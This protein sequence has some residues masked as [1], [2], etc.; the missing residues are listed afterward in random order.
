MLCG[1]KLGNLICNKKRGEPASFLHKESLKSE[2]L[3]SLLR[4]KE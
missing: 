4:K 2:I 1:I 3:L